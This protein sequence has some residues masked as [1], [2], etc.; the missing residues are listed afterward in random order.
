ML[1]GGTPC[2]EINYIE[3]SSSGLYLSPARLHEKKVYLE[4]D[5]EVWKLGVYHLEAGTERIMGAWNRERTRS[6]RPIYWVF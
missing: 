5:D 1:V 4:V 6:R 3:S 2:L